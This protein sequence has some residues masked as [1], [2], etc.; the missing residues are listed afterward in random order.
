MN[1]D[2]DDDAMQQHSTILIWFVFESQAQIYESF[3]MIISF[4]SEVSNNLGI[5]NEFRAQIHLLN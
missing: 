2:D 4:N 1:N 3:G 5:S